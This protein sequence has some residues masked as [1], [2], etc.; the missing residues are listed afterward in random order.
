MECWFVSARNGGLWFSCGNNY[1][2]F[3]VEV[4]VTE[5][6]PPVAPLQDWDQAAEFAMNF[7]IDPLLLV[8]MSEL[9]YKTDIALQDIQIDQGP[10]R[11][12]A[13]SRGSAEINELVARL[14]SGPELD[15]QP[16]DPACI[17]EQVR[18]DLWPATSVDEVKETQPQILKQK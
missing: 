12:R 8:P 7:E 14:G 18:L 2:Y 10:T 13:Y 1:V 17:V 5:D 16:A 11:L 6:E 3:A 15:Q 9:G 4:N